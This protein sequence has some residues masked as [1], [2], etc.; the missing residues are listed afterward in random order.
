MA[1]TVPIG[2]GWLILL[3]VVLT[4]GVTTIV[5]V[6]GLFVLAGLPTLAHLAAAGERR[7]L[8]LI[9]PGRPVSRLPAPRDP[10]HGR[11]AWPE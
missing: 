3:L 10:E 6:A 4:V 5:V 11:V 8:R 2:L 9:F 7:R 1:T